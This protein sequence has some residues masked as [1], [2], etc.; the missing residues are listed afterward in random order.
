MKGQHAI[1]L[2]P[3]EIYAQS[4]VGVRTG[5]YVVFSIAAV[6]ILAAVTT[7]ARLA[8][9]AAEQQLYN[10]QNEANNV[11]E[12]ERQ[13]QELRKMRHGLEERIDLY[14]RAA[15]PLEIRRVIAT[16]INDLPVGAT[17]ESLDLSA[18]VQ[19]STRSPRSKGRDEKAEE[20]APRVLV[21]EI[22]GFA[23]SD[24]AIAELVAALSDR[25][26]FQRVGLDFSRTREVRGQSARE[27]RVSFR[28]DLDAGYE[29]LALE[30]EEL[31][32]IRD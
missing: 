16:I 29:V 2:L 10:T 30:R 18:G 15:L 7:H 14:E 24:Q 27:F 8:L 12:I 3:S 21:G 25:P 20:Q 31:M 6:L 5:R 9:S 32:G 26:P 1:D 22:S 28:I 17:L 4:Q 19:R 23:A 11:L 13:A